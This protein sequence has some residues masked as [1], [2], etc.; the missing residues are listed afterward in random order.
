MTVASSSRVVDASVGVKLVL[1]EAHADQAAALFEQLN[2]APPTTLYVPDLFYVECTNVLWKHVRRR[3]LSAP[4]AAQ[5][6]AILHELKMSVV[7]TAELMLAALDLAVH[8]DISVYDACYVA[9]SDRLRAPM[10]TA[11]ERLVRK[12]AGA[13]HQIEWLGAARGSDFA[14]GTP[15]G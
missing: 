11:D 10:I 7:S 12:L 15:E 3:E 5:G 6:A 9:L 1:P 8:H 14:G 13:E 2:E 4:A